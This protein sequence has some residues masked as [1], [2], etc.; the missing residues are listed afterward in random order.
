MNKLRAPYKDRQCGIECIPQTTIKRPFHYKDPKESLFYK[1]R[2]AKVKKTVRLGGKERQTKTK[3][4][5][6]QREKRKKENVKWVG[7]SLR[8]TTEAMQQAAKARKDAKQRPYHQRCRSRPLH[9]IQRYQKSTELVIRKLPFQ[10]LVREV[11]QEF[12]PDL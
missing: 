5:K 10:K 9:E 12:K 4:E 11:A 3:I 7:K 1:E 8:Q 2:I 6:Q